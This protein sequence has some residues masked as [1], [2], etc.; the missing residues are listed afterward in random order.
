MKRTKN[1]EALEQFFAEIFKNW[2]ISVPAL[3]LLA[4]YL[5]H[6][7]GVT[8]PYQRFLIGLQQI[9]E[10]VLFGFAALLLLILAR[11]IFV[12]WH[13]KKHY[14]YFQ[15][16]PHADD[17]VNPATLNEFIRRVHGSKRS[18]FGRLLYGKEWNTFLIHYRKHKDRGL[19]YVFYIG[20]P[21]DRLGSIQRH[22]LAAYP[23]AEI[24]AA[25]HMELP[26]KKAKSGRLLMRRVKEE[27]TLSLAKFKTDRL[28]G[29]LKVM[30]PGTWIQL[31]F[32]ADSERK[33]KRRI[34]EAEKKVK[35]VKNYRE[36]TAFD[37]EEEKS[38]K[39][40]FAGNE[41]SF[42]VVLSV[43]S[44]H[45]RKKGVIKEVAVALEEVLHDVNR[46]AFYRLRGMVQRVPIPHPFQMVWTGSELANL[47]HLPMLGGSGVAEHVAKEIPHATR[48]T[49]RLPTNVL[50]DKSGFVFGD[51][52]HPLIDGRQVLINPMALSKHFIL[53]G[54]TGSGKSTVLNTILTSF[55]DAFVQNAVAMGFS[56]IDPKKETATIVLNQLLKKEKDGAQVDWSKVHWISFKDAANPP[57]MNLLYRMPGVPDN[58]LT[59]Q[60]MRIIRETNPNQAAQ[61]ERLLK[62]CIQTL[63]ADKSKEHT[64]L[65][66]RPLLMNS[67]FRR[68]I[69]AR[70]TPEPE[71][72]DLVEFWLHESEDLIRVSGAAILNR[73]DMFYSNNFLKRIFGQTGFNFPIRQWLDEGHIVFY[74][75]GGMGEEET[76]LIGGYL[77]YLYYRVADMRPDGSMLHQLVIDEAQRVP[78][79]ILPEIHA[80]MRSK[81]LS[82]G[83]ASQTIEQLPA[84]LQKSATNVVANAFACKQGESGAKIAARM[85]TVSKPDGS[86]APLYSEGYFKKLAVR[87][88]VIKTEDNGE[89]V[90]AVVQVPPLNRYLPDGQMAKF[91]T[92][93]IDQSNQW[94][95][96]KAKELEQKNGLPIAAIDAAIQAYLHDG[97]PVEIAPQDTDVVRKPIVLVRP[98]ERKIKEVNLFDA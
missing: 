76:A 74:D 3:V 1:D 24:Y 12:T 5:L 60:I 20:A 68:S 84:G 56:F 30:E 44:D 52:V 87:R 48:G 9:L 58:V 65:G 8:V 80:E 96:A 97:G 19:Q 27:S 79:T 66:V 55:I 64:I 18:R 93:E 81:G 47:F 50:S 46:L 33:L 11:A 14:R 42:E 78:A 62:K 73:L 31:S 43:A 92:K 36:R 71:H 41:V 75:F 63:L 67:R 17:E 86:D 72:I 95:H 82:L 77:S 70:I 35:G 59:D 69:L 49:Q 53:T 57:A 32:A 91:G 40:R 15:L 45:S 51:L 54:I 21:A 39:T 90:F 7:K 37:R 28:P 16:M 10:P 89:T 83:V 4:G 26:S 98:T 88:C 6:K 94:T 13:N 2:K 25:D 34:V 38:F 61:A 85:F 22:M 23:K 29:V